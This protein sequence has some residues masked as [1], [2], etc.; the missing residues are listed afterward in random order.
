M[1][2]VVAQ[3]QDQRKPDFTSRVEL[4]T[5]DVIVRDNSGQFVADLKKDD[6]EV[7]EDGV[8][9]DVVSFALTHGGRSYNA[10]RRRRRRRCRKA[11]S[12]RRRGR[13]TTPPAASS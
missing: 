7:Y 2:G 6:F 1:A 12:C 8:K 4:V 5:T 13:P 3:A 9:Q 11:S 10:S